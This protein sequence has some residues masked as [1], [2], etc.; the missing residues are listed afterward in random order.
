MIG[1]ILSTLQNLQGGFCPPCQKLQGVLCPPC[2]KLEGGFVHLCQ[3]EQ[4]VLCPGGVLS[5]YRG[6]RGSNLYRHVFVMN[7]SIASEVAVTK[8]NSF[9]AF[10]RP[11]LFRSLVCIKP[12]LKNT[13]SMHAELDGIFRSF[14]ATWH[15]SV[16][17]VEDLSS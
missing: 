16:F 15:K 3:N 7:L 9:A 5:G 1:G 2:K 17:T 13:L 4:G 8:K 14:T 11:S 10:W 12:K 6:L